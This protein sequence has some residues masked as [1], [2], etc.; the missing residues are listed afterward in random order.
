[1]V[2]NQSYDQARTEGEPGER[3]RERERERKEGGKEERDCA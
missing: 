3:E 1:M 2:D